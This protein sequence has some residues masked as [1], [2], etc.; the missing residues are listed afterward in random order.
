VGRIVAGRHSL[1]WLGFHRLADWA[2]YTTW[3]LGL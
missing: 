3:T 1:L 2:A